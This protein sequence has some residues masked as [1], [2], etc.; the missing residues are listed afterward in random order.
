MSQIGLTIDDI[1]KIV[2]ISFYI[3]AASVTVLTYRSAKNGLLNTVNTEYQKKVIA[4]LEEISNYLSSEF[5]STSPHYWAK[6]NSIRDSVDHIN[7]VFLKNKDYILELGEYPFG[8][9]YPEKLLRLSNFVT[10]VKTDP[11]V[12]KGVREIITAFLENR[13]QR[14]GSIYFSELESYSESI[15]AG[16][17]LLRTDGED[18]K[19]DEFHNSIVEKLNDEGCG[20]SKVESD[21]NNIRLYIQMYLESFNPIKN[22]KL[23]AL[24]ALQ[25]PED[26]SI[27]QTPARFLKGLLGRSTFASTTVDIKQQVQQLQEE[28]DLLR[29]Y[30]QQLETENQELQEATGNSVEPD[31]LSIRDRVLA[32]LKV[33]RQSAGGKAIEAFIKELRL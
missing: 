27:N 29:S 12:P 22:V 26:D 23:E 3:T 21:I 32:K 1:L 15:V 14:T 6:S 31:Y 5:D 13:I 19:F 7:E 8:V 10:K 9:L 2:Q 28:L 33:G 17:N 20:I 18:P 30:S 4:K 24:Q 16:E 25:F 11:F